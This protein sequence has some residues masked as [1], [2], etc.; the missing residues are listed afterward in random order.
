MKTS[1]RSR[2]HSVDNF[3]MTDPVP[4]RNRLLL[5]LPLLV[6]VSINLSAATV[7]VL[8]GDTGFNFS[9]SSVSIQAGDTVEWVWKADGHSTT[10]GTPGSPNGLWDSGVQNSG[11]TFFHTFPIA[12]SFPYYC[13]PHGACCGMVGTINV[14]AASAS[15]TPIPKGSVRIQLAQA[16]TGLTAPLSVVASPD[17]SGRLFIVQQ[18][19]KVLILKGGV[20]GATP[21]LDVGPR[22][23]SLNPG[24]DERGLLGF[25][26]HPD[27]NNSATPGF[28]KVYTYTSE[29]VAGAADFTVP[30]TSPFDHQSVV[31]EWQVSTSNPDAINPATRREVMRIDEPQ[32]NHN[33]GQ[34]AFRPS[35]HY[36]YI[37]LG[38]GGAANDVGAGHNP[39]T[40]NAQDKS[41]VLGKILRIDPVDPALT[42]GSADPVSANG[43][44][45]VPH[46]N[47]FVGQTGVV[48]EI[49]DLGLRNP[50]RFSFDATLD[51]LIIGDVGQNNIEEVDAGAP[52]KNYGW[53]K[54]EGSYLFNPAN[55]S[56]S[57][58]PAPDPAL[59]EP[60][61]EYSHTDGSAVIGGFIYRGALL[62]ALSGKYVFGD[63]ALGSNGRLF[64]SDLTN[65]VIQ[66]LRLGTQDAPLGLFLKGFG[67]DSNGELYALADS[68]VG[69]SGTGGKAF[70]IVSIQPSS[71]VSR[72]V[73]G[74]AG[75]FDIGLL[76]S[77]PAIECRSGGPSKD[78]QI[79]LTFPVAVTF[80]GAKV[81][82][83]TGG[84]GDLSGSPSSS[85]DRKQVTVNLTN[86]SNV[87]IIT[88]TLLGVNDG[89]NTYDV[90]VQ[91]GVLIGDV[92]ASGVVT[93]GDANLCKAQA[94]Q[95][96]TSANFRN[97]IN[98]TGSITTGDVNIIKQNALNQ[99][100]AS[101]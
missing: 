83:G 94:L 31:A 12:G 45:R 2:G 39:T 61:A 97:D 56:I 54:K 9:P 14:G 80:S 88:V 4:Q 65:G 13:T 74:G 27:F 23:V 81:T 59:T 95:P 99:L 93:S 78:Y 86:V 29:P 91:M 76:G 89:T 17:G 87:Q 46:T 47:P 82:P 22:L 63:L 75:A 85:L 36:L 41:T 60:V 64:Y 32:S 68:N 72:K 37:A 15:P 35:D 30:D 69:P 3:A 11:F 33:A 84:T 66:E 70:K 67:Q 26:F 16:A 40:G 50:F 24:Y 52:G 6:L 21:F 79:V 25:A 98:A 34:L 19:G 48:A 18:T 77:T 100:P 58:D 73:H 38:D 96:V 42:T 5:I 28:R 7:Q 49:Y 20:V 92:N 57:S 62:P 1:F 90:S 10:S 51:Q 44:Y 8:V 43:K 101:P 53:N 55:G 71:A